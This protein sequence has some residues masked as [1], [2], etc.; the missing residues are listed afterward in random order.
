MNSAKKAYQQL[1]AE[2]YIP[3]YAQPWWLDAVVGAEN[4]EVAL[5]FNA[6][7]KV[8]GAMPYCIS[9]FYGLQFCRLPTLT[10]YNYIYF[11]IPSEIKQHRLYFRR[12]W[13]ISEL[14][15]QLPKI[16][17]FNQNFH[18]ELKSSLPFNINGFRQTTRYTY[19]LNELKNL[20]AIKSNFKGSIRTYIK[21]ANRTL[22]VKKNTPIIDFIDFQKKVVKLGAKK[23]YPEEFLI[24]LHS[25]LQSKGQSICLSAIDKEN[26]VHA[27]AYIIWDEK[28]AYYLAGLSHPLY[29][30]SGAV[31]LLMWEAIKYVSSKVDSF[32]FEGSMV[33]S[34]ESFYRAF[35][36]TQTPYH[37]IYKMKNKFFHTLALWLGKI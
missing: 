14:I 2:E 20:E 19:I 4:W 13:I 31:P 26:K 35:G 27:M 23:R 33:P 9:S 37:Q 28:R 18:P 24:K 10:T 3:I 29:K 30:T 6:D 34:I 8:I 32:D 25:V 21:K 5:V 11:Y 17:F 16:T 12:K 15:K 22:I 1:C 7:N 36:A